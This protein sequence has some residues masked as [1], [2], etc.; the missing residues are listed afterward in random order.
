MRGS[1]FKALLSVSSAE[2]E[3]NGA[4]SSLAVP[5]AP[6]GTNPEPRS[7]A[8]AAVSEHL[9]KLPRQNCRTRPCSPQGLAQ[10]LWTLPGEEEQ[11]TGRRA[12]AARAALQRLQGPQETWP[13]TSDK[14][15]E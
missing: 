2:A 10:I 1:C 11:G 3:N 8:A 5:G 13:L 15:T 6:G 4:F 9:A 12:T 14:G 7:R